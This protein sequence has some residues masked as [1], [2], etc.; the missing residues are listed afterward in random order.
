MKRKSVTN[1]ATPMQ[2]SFLVQRLK[3][4]FKSDGPLAS[5]ADAFAFGGGLRNGGL[6]DEAMELLSDIFRFD[7][8]GSSEFEWGAVPKALT[9]IAENADRYKTFQFVIPM[10][11]VAKGWRNRS[12]PEPASATTA[13][14]YAICDKGWVEE[15]KS[16]ICTWAAEEY[17]RE[18][19]EDTQLSQTL[20][21]I[22]KWDTYT[23]G[24]LELDNGFFFFID[25][26]MWEKTARL[27][28]ISVS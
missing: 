17:S 26:D 21:P 9:R 25:H 14:I 11:S 18:L 1:A 20:R 27:F 22:E 3:A 2:R 16:R 13:T 23:R 28:G 19:K 15:V 7:Y 8:M 10:S 4:P 6:S 12:A 24:W 5:L